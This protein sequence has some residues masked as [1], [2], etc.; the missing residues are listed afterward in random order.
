[1]VV[2]FVDIGRCDRVVD[3]T[4]SENTTVHAYLVLAVVGAVQEQGEPGGC[5]FNVHF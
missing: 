4:S 5:S 2:F 3:T 1:M